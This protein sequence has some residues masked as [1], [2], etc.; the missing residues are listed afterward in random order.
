M[1]SIPRTGRAYAGLS[2]S[3]FNEWSC[4]AWERWDEK[5]RFAY[6]YAHRAAELDDGDAVV[7]IVLGR[8]LLFRRRFDEA[9]HHVE[10]ALA[11][12]SNDADVLAHASLCLGL[13]GDAGLAV[14]LARKAK[15]LNPHFPQWYVAGEAQGLFLLERYDEASQTALKTPGG[16]V[17]LPAWLAAACALSGDLARAR[18]YLDRFLSDFTERITF[19]RSPDPGEPL[20]WLL[21][22]NPFRRAADSERLARGL[23]SAGLE[24][25]P[26][27]GRPEAVAHPVSGTAAAVFRREGSLWR[28]AFDGLAVQLSDQKGFH[29][30]SRLLSQ[31]GKE[32]HCLELA[33]RPEED[34]AADPVL[35]ARARREIQERVRDLQSEIDNADAMNDMGRAT[36]AREELDRIVELLSGALGLRGRSRALG[37]GAERA[38]SAVTWRIRSTIKKITSAHPRLGRHLENSLK[39][40]TFCTYQPETPIAWVS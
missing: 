8:I 5:E 36:R 16:T 29:D 30:L 34:G 19:G 32:I 40:G 25:D 13:L 39:T 7:Q 28:I 24:N 9:A 4:Q 2:L 1:Q 33:N 6:Q 20:R 38:R 3:H 12:N 27:E 17:D 11:L 23:Q 22:I 26:D 37:S 15:R 35:D 14:E 21:H 10:R 31:P 18:S